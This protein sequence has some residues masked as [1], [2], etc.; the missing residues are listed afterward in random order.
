MIYFFFSQA[1]NKLA[2]VM[3]RR[4]KVRGGHQG[5]DTEVH[6][7]EKENRKLQLEL[8]AEKEKFSTAI[9][10]YQNQ[11]AEMEAVST[12]T[13]PENKCTAY[14]QI[15]LPERISEILREAECWLPIKILTVEK[16]TDR[17]RY[18]GG[19]DLG[20]SRISQYLVSARDLEC[21]LQD[22][23]WEC[24][25][26][27]WSFITIYWFVY[28]CLKASIFLLFPSASWFFEARN[29]HIWMKS[30][31]GLVGMANS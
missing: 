18:W 25:D 13:L 3:N 31:W 22:L 19:K 7:K 27:G 12:P 29:G 15:H 1:V 14:K 17:Q 6:K 24:I 21:F 23:S 20:F 4:E 28:F 30:V 2:E 16:E 10:K 5:T 9:V 26:D 8:K 11:L